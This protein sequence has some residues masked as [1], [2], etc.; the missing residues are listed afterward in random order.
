MVFFKI[1]MAIWPFIRE[2]IFGKKDPRLTMHHHPTASI[3]AATC[4]VLSVMN[5]GFMYTSFMLTK[6]LQEA[7]KHNPPTPDMVEM[8]QLRK[9]LSDINLRIEQL[10]TPKK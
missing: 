2:L 6:E 9:Q 3:L 5:V 4:I 1:L 7:R 8:E 10:T